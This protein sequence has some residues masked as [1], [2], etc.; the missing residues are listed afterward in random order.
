[1][2]NQNLS[3]KTIA[4]HSRGLV[5]FQNLGAPQADENEIIQFIKKL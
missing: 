4:E 3:E 1:M 2:R 5:K